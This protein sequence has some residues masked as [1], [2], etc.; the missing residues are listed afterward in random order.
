MESKKQ[1]RSELFLYIEELHQQIKALQED[2]ADLEILLETATQHGDLIETQLRDRAESAIEKKETL[3][4]E[5]EV[6]K[7]DKAVLEILLETT[8]E[9]ADTVETELQDLVDL[10][11]RNSEKQLAQFLEAVP[12]GVFVVDPQGNPYYANQRAKQLLG[13]GITAD[14]TAAKFASI[15]GVY[16]ANSEELYPAD[17]QPILLALE[18][19]RSTADDLEIRRSDKIIPLEMWATPICNEQEKIIYAIAVFQDITERKQ[20]EQERIKYTNQLFQ[21][22]QAFERFV[23]NAFLELLSKKS[24]V[25]VELGDTV[26]REMSVLFTDLRDF[27][28]L[29]ENISLEENFNFINAFLSRMEPA[30]RENNGFIDKFIGDAIMALFSGSADDA[31]QAGISMLQRLADY[32]QTRQAK[33]RSPINIGIGINTGYLMLGTVGG[34]KRMDGTVISDA[35]NLT[36]RIEELTKKYGVSLLISHY[37]YLRLKNANR[38]SYRLIARVQVKGKSKAVTVYEIFDADSPSIKEGKLMTK[39]DFERAIL[40]YHHGDYS[41]AA[42]LFQSC[43]NLSPGDRVGQIYLNLCQQHL[44]Q[45]NA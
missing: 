11:I 41:Q 26:A 17:R 37:T 20:A 27:T 15:Y 24:I 25:D 2:K 9:H 7:Q 38:Y 39:T 5:I 10:T 4:E 28:S 44:L 42:K 29:S 35:V 18:G 14:S 36:S 40:S 45:N 33:H 30:I 6:L 43:L 16:A 31:V 8:T 32:N 22:N 1:S 19:K 34:E 21:L 13:L 23:P 12:V 3:T